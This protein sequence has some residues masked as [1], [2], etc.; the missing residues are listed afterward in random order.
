MRNFTG[1]PEYFDSREVNERIAELE[2]RDLT[3][4][5]SFTEEKE[6]EALTALR[7]E[8]E[9][10]E[11]EWDYGI[12]LI[13]EDCRAEHVEEDLSTFM[14]TDEIPSWVVIDWDATAEEYFDAKRTYTFRGTTYYAR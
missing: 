9:H 2:D 7:D 10:D 5:L 6:L 4:E 11:G 8:A 14:N 12:T 3:P 13:R 1:T